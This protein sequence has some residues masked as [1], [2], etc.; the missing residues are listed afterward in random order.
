MDFKNIKDL[1]PASYNPRKITDKQLK[2][3]GESME[4]FGDLSGIIRNIRTGNLVGGHQRCKHFDPSWPITSEAHSDA[5]GTTATGFVETPTGRFSYREVDWDLKKEMAANISAN[6]SG[7]YFDLA[8]L[9]PI[10]IEL[11]EKPIN[12][13]LTGFAPE[14]LKNLLLDEKEWTDSAKT[15]DAAIESLSEKIRKAAAEHPQEMSKALAVIIQNGRGNTCLI[16]SDPNTKDIIAELRRYA[17]S[18]EN[19]PLECL[20]RSLL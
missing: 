4:T 11:A 6:K 1:S 3:L 5:T 16:L 15:A 9:K 14:E 12:I 7:G 13:E 18:G 2:T 17:D 8:L 10:L 19:S 20:M